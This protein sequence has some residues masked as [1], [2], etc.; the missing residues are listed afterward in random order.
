VTSPRR[1]GLADTGQRW[2]P[3]SRTQ[4]IAAAAAAVAPLACGAAL[5]H[6][7]L[8]RFVLLVA[9]VP[10]IVGLGLLAPSGLL[11]GLAIWLVGMGLVRRLFDTIAPLGGNGLGDPLL[12]VE[13]AIMVVLTVVAVQKGGFRDR[14]RLA[15][16][17]LVLTVLMVVEAANPLQ[18]GPLVG[19]GGMVFLLVPVLAFWVG[20][21]LVD[22]S[23]LRRLFVLIAALGVPAVLYG[24]AQQ[25]WGLPSW[26]RA[27]VLSSGYAALHVGTVSRAFGTFSASSE[28]ESFLAIGVIIC[29]AGLTRRSL[30]PILLAVG[31]L[32]S[33]GVFYDS[34][35]GTVLLGA[36]ALAL[37]LSARRRLP[38]VPALLGGV[39]GLL[40]LVA[41]AGHFASQASVP[42][43]GNS[44]LVQH[45]LQGLAN[46]LNSKDSTLGGHVSEM[47]SGLRSAI[48]NP[49][50]RGTGAVTLAASRF[51]ATGEGTE[52]DP[53]NLAV[54]FGIPGLLSYL[55]IAILGLAT[56]Y[57]LA[58]WIRRW[59][60]LAALGLLIV[61]FLQWSN[62]GQYAVAWL[63]W[64]VLGWVDRAWMLERPMKGRQH[65]FMSGARSDETDGERG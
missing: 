59:W 57:R 52:A 28:Y 36:A 49:I 33:Y 15:N 7:G 18:G 46:P 13:P 64:L 62:G 56:A 44:A 61:T 55:V 22:E 39:A 5:V 42:A 32:L 6:P 60:A 23:V 24:L 50:G 41:V 26:D 30:I 8:D 58:A 51:G 21:S 31:G 65:V 3:L 20:R 35:R 37:M 48:T 54:A 63:P 17:V 14:T 45:Q 38:P 9:L 1:T 19:I 16:A 27:W 2:H 29:A 10:A 11:Y 12:L 40:I 43:R 4:V 47:T 25:F 34:S 53:S